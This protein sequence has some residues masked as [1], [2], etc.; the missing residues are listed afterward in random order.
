MIDTHCIE[1][2]M[3]WIPITEKT[4]CAGYSLHRISY[5]LDTDSTDEVV[6]DAHYI[7]DIT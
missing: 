4:L 2:V 6:L 1:D 7:G 3:C 5:V